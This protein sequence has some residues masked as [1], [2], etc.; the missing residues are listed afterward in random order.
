MNKKTRNIIT[1]LYV[2][3]LVALLVGTTFSYFTVINVASVSP[4]VSAETAT[5]DY[6]LF[7][8]G[9]DISIYPNDTNFQ[10]GMGN[11][12][13]DTYA[14][15]YVKHSG[16]DTPAS[17]TYNVYIQIDKNSLTYSTSDNKPEL[18]M[19]VVDTNGN[20]VTEIEGLTYTSVSDGKGNTIKGF[21]VTESK[22]RFYI[23]SNRTIK[24]LNEIT[25]K[26][27]VRVTYVNLGDVQDNNYDKELQG[28]IRIEKV[29]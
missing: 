25:E 7:D 18:V 5:L 21:D 13:S 9:N 1:A 27:D 29:G 4:S 6:I 2:I 19:E 8:T 28:Y 26:W 14:R 17:V 22:G 16:G 3:A 11:L 24:T 10:K 12:S 23:V 20:P 15:A